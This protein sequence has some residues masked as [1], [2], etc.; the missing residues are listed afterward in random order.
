MA[1][2]LIVLDKCRESLIYLIQQASVGTD[3][4]YSEKNSADKV[5]PNV[6]V[7]ANSAQEAPMGSGNFWVILEV[8]IKSIAAVA[9]PM[10]ADLPDPKPSSDLLTA[11][12][13]AVLEVDN[14][15]EQM[16]AAVSDF[17]VQGFD[18]QK[19]LEQ[20]VDGDCWTET[21][22]RRCYCCGSSLT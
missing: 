12:V 3:N 15:A 17:C 20:S 1:N 2:P 21:W 5:A 16:S 13:L 8:K 11:N 9:A 14:L 7:G 10:D 18:E 6:S 19:E 22:R 4:V